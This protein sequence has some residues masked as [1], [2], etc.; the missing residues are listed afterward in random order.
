MPSFNPYPKNTGGTN[1]RQREAFQN[2]KSSRNLHQGR[3]PRLCYFVLRLL[4]P[5]H[6]KIERGE[7]YKNSRNHFFYRVSAEFCGEH[8]TW[9]LNVAHTLFMQDHKFDKAASFYEPII[10]KQFENVSFQ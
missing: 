3:R 2:V 8:D 7:T 1:G 6:L 5:F 10:S 4:S 9:K